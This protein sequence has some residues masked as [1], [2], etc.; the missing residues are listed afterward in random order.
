MVRIP[1]LKPQPL[2]ETKSN[3]SPNIPS[4]LNRVLQG[5]IGTVVLGRASYVLL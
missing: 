5:K 1:N 2:E 3:S 4:E